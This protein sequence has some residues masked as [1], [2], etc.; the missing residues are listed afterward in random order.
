M[1]QDEIKKVFI[2]GGSSGSFDVLLYLLPHLQPLDHAAIII[3][4]HR[5][6][7]YDTALTDVLS[8]RTL[9]EVKEVEEKEPGYPGP[10]GGRVMSSSR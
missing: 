4:L 7:G 9:A 6:N 1:A 3:I 2:I 8:Y 10:A 5:K